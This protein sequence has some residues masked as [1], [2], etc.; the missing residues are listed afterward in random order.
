M[1]DHLVRKIVSLVQAFTGL[2]TIEILT[3]VQAQLLL[4]QPW[5]DPAGEADKQQAQIKLEKKHILARQLL[6]R[7]RKN[8]GEKWVSPFGA[9]FPNPRK[10]ASY[11][12]YHATYNPETIS[13]MTPEELAAEFAE[14]DKDLSGNSPPPHRASGLTYK[15]NLSHIHMHRQ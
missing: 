10:K 9:H 2:E 3:P 1:F 14:F 6:N 4:D 13:Y 7:E 12:F 15:S 11:G 5:P 8:V